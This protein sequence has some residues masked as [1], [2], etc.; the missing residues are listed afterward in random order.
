MEYGEN[1]SS[2]VCIVSLIPCC[3]ILHLYFSEVVYLYKPSGVDLN[4]ITLSLEMYKL[5]EFSTEVSMMT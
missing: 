1:F 2:T 3:L 4:L 5:K